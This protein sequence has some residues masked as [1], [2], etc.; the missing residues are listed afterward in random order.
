MVFVDD[1]HL[2][3]NGSAILLHQLA[4]T[5]AATVLA[6]VRSGEPA[7]DPV[8][9]LWKD[10][11][12]ERIEIGIL[13]DAAIEELLV[14]VL[15]GPVDAASVRQLVDRSRGS[16]MFLR[17]LV[18]GALESGALVDEGGIWRLQGALRPTARLV[19]LVAL[20]LGDLPGSERAVLE[21][22]TLGE[23]LGQAALGQLSDPDAV[24]AVE[25]KGLIT[26]RV[27]GRRVQVWL[28]HPVYGDVVRLGI[29]AR[30]PAFGPGP[31]GQVARTNMRRD[32]K[33]KPSPVRKGAAYSSTWERTASRSFSGSVFMIT[34]SGPAISVFSSQYRWKLG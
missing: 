9:A 29:S 32:G 4:L 11:P 31:L 5:R 26:S 15:R 12:A 34:A 3:D 24:D 30:A 17:E 20:R 22:L 13:D 7:P 21:L 10:G 1:A 28:A 2:L 25:S 27:D 19:K 23:P 16:P 18:T 6:T 33:V 14:S 8:V